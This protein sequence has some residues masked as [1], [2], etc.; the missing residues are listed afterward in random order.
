MSARDVVA[1]IWFG[2]HLMDSPREPLEPLER[3]LASALAVPGVSGAL[4]VTGAP[5][6]VHLALARRADHLYLDGRH[7]GSI[8]AARVHVL[9]WDRLRDRALNVA[10]TTNPATA[11]NAAIGSLED[12]VRVCLLD[13][14]DVFY[15]ELKERQLRE[16][17]DLASFSGHHDRE[18]G[19]TWL[20]PEL[21][22]REHLYMGPQFASSTM[23]FDRGVWEAVGGFDEQLETASDWDFAMRVQHRIGWQPFHDVTGTGARPTDGID[24][25]AIVRERG[26]ELRWT[27][28]PPATP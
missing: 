9:G 23:V 22:W 15:P 24:E 5:T 17:E 26:S 11:L 21:W 13:A 12:G 14:G 3:S 27:S 18:T 6:T 4:V 16:L 19:A 25:F 10:L 7:Y 8:D 28:S 1:V 20:P 2:R